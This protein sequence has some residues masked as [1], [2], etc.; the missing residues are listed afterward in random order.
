MTL[1]ANLDAADA[2]VRALFERVDG[3]G[4]GATP[5]LPAIADALAEFAADREYLDRWIARLG[6]RS[7]ALPIHAPV[8]GP[9]LTLVHRPEGRMSAVHDH[10]TWV[11]ICP[12]VGTE[13]H[14]RWQVVR[15][16]ADATP[17]IELADDRALA[18]TE[19]ATLLPP[20]DVHDHGH[21]VGRGAP[22]HVLLLLGDDQTRFTRNEWDAATGRHRVLVPGDSGRW[23]ASDD[24]PEPTGISR[25]P[26][27][28]TPSP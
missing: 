10:G 12:I 6:D 9:R 16:S 23:L 27:P 3:F 11:A 26:Q 25:P 21:L 15:G 20:D 13:T 8:R 5:D 18:A 4:G 2:P 14:R 19:A 7:G 17:G 28:R 24:W 22:A 1:E